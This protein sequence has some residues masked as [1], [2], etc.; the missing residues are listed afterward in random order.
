MKTLLLT[1]VG[2]PRPG[3]CAFLQ[4]IPGLELLVRV[5]GPGA[6]L[7]ILDIHTPE[8]DDWAEMRRVKAGVSAPYCI[9]IVSTSRQ[10]AEARAAGADQV[11][12]AGFTATEFMTTLAACREV[13]HKK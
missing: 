6:D 12:L 4:S 9:A 3:L 1:P 5:A 2:N 10:M 11:L 7:L 8:Y 13:H